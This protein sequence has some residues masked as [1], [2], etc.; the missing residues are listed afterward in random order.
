EVIEAALQMAEVDAES[1]TMVEAHGTGTKI[2]DSIEVEALKRAFQTNKKAYCAIGSVKSSIGHLN[3]AAG[4]AGLIKTILSLTNK[5]IPPSLHVLNPN[6]KIEFENTPF[7][8]N[9][10]LRDWNQAATPRRAA[11]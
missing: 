9:H 6:P 7:Y 3:E 11:V 2:G 1:I 4:I 10:S 5:Q 8:I